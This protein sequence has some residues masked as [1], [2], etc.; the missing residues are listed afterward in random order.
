VFFLVRVV[1]RSRVG[2]IHPRRAEQVAGGVLA[3]RALEGKSLLVAPWRSA[4][5]LTS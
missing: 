4:P 3:R 2:P 5:R 1:G